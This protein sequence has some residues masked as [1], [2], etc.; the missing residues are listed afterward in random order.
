MLLDS[1]F[2]YLAALNLYFSYLCSKKMNET[3]KSVNRTIAAAIAIALVLTGC[4][5]GRKPAAKITFP[6]VTVPTIYSD[7]QPRA[8]YL[9]MH[10]WDRF[11]FSDTAYVGSG[12]LATEQAIVDYISIFPYMPYNKAYE[13][14]NNTLSLAE[15]HPA[16]YAFFTTMMEKYLFDV[17]SQLHNDEYY[18][19]VLEHQLSSVVLDDY[20][21]I[22]PQT[23]INELGK[24][25]PGTMGADIHFAMTT[26]RK[27]ALSDFKTDFTLVMF[28][29]LDCGNCR[30]MAATIEA[31]AS[32]KEM[33]R[34]NRL[35]IIAL[36]PGDDLENWRKHIND[37]PSS[38]I[39]GY[40]YGREI[41]DSLTYALRIIPTVYLFD[42]QRTVIM[43]DVQPAY[44]DYYMNSI[45]NPEL[46]SGVR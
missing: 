27:A 36:Y 30:E 20:H 38:W 25:R 21:K 45:L 29:N 43:R 9:A 2:G 23:L 33:Q 26:G 10:Y 24:N 42:K 5:Q 1:F 12:A 8:E 40:D 44:V 31:G 39:H 13:G 11:N 34:R 7:P 28:H 32:I 16:M 41:G 35:T 14:I 22:R 18:I 3:M 15:R 46:Q 4:S 37:M 17:N 19:P 6:S